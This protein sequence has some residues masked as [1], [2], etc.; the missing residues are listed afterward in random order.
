MNNFLGWFCNH[1][2]LQ[3]LSEK[4]SNPLFEIPQFGVCVHILCVYA[5][6]FCVY[7]IA[8]VCILFVCVCVCV[9]VCSYIAH[10]DK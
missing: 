5:Y 3:N 4:K 9:C 7:C 2:F 8:S 1:S 6:I 10:V